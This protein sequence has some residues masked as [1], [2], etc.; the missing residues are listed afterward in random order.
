MPRIAYVNGRYLPLSE[1][2]VNIED[3]G[4]QFADGI[5]EVLAVAG[6]RFLDEALHM[7]R[8]WRSL[9]ALDIAAPMGGAALRLVLREVVRRNRV[10]DGLLYLQVTRGVAR[11]EHAFP[12]ASRRPGR[13]AGSRPVA[14]ALVVT[15]RGLAPPSG[16]VAAWAA[17]AITAPDERWARCDIKSIALL[18]NV[19]AKERARRAGA[20]EA[21]LIDRDG[22]VSEGASTTVWVVDSA[23]T[24]RTRPL[25]H[26][27]LPGCTRAALVA[28][29][30]AAGIGFEERAVGEAEL[31]A[32]REVFV[33]SATSWVRP[34]TRL[35]G[36]AVGD[37][38]AGPV[39][40]RLSALLR[41]PARAGSKQG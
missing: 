7:A 14:P 19:L 32:A 34:I 40:R 20:V 21:I 31:H 23:G 16:D 41:D 15:C 11:R 10:R 35:D 1:A 28:E 3:R 12:Q 22:L 2:S 36:A 27:I 37:G 29:L 5:Y 4:Y 24:L 25:G 33:T 18:P 38:A 9:D 30:E 26:A 17:A 6:G 13:H 39:A 8:L